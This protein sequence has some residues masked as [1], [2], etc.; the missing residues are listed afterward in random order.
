MKKLLT[1]LLCLTMACCMWGQLNTNGHEYVDLGLPSGTLW[2]KTNLGADLPIQ[3]GTLYYWGQ[4]LDNGRLVSRDSYK[5]ADLRYHGSRDYKIELDIEDDIVAQTLGGDWHTPT[6]EEF[7][8]LEENCDR[9]LVYADQYGGNGRVF[10]F[11]SRI[12]GNTI[13][14]MENKDKYTD[15]SNTSWTSEYFKGFY[16]YLYRKRNGG[17]S[18]YENENKLP[19]RP[20][21][22]KRTVVQADSTEIAHTEYDSCKTPEDML[23]HRFMLSKNKTPSKNYQ[24]FQDI[25]TYISFEGC[26]EPDGYHQKDHKVHTK[27]YVYTRKLNPGWYVVTLP[28]VY[29][30]TDGKPRGNFFFGTG[31]YQEDWISS[32]PVYPV[33][34][35]KRPLSYNKDFKYDLRQLLKKDIGMQ[36]FTFEV[37]TPGTYYIGMQFLCTGNDDWEV[38]ATGIGSLKGG[39][40]HKLEAFNYTMVEQEFNESQAPMRRLAGVPLPESVRKRVD[41]YTAL[42]L[43]SLTPPEAY[44]KIRE[45]KDF[46][47]EMDGLFNRI[48]INYLGNWYKNIDIDVT[49]FPK[50]VYTYRNDLKKG[51]GRG[52]CEDGFYQCKVL[53]VDNN[54]RETMRAFGLRLVDYQKAG[55]YKY[56]IKYLSYNEDARLIYNLEYTNPKFEEMKLANGMCAVANHKDKD[57]M[58][59]VIN[60]LWT[61]A[62]VDGMM[63]GEGVAMFYINGL[64]YMQRATYKRGV[65]EGAVS[66]S[67]YKTYSDGLPRT[68]DRTSCYVYVQGT[69]EGLYAIGE[70]NNRNKRWVDSYGQILI[71]MHRMV[72]NFENGKAIVLD[73]R[74]RER[75]IDTYGMDLGYTE[76]EMDRI[77][78][79]DLYFVQG[80]WRTDIWSY[81][82]ER[83]ALNALLTGSPVYID[84]SYWKNM[85]RALEIMDNHMGEKDFEVMR[86]DLYAKA[87]QMYYQYLED[88]EHLANEYERL[89]I[90]AS[91]SIWDKLQMNSI[92]DFLTS[93]GSSSSSSS[94]SS[95][96]EKEEEVKETTSTTT[97]EKKEEKYSASLM[98]LNDGSKLADMTVTVVFD[99]DDIVKDFESISTKPVIIEWP[100]EWGTSVKVKEIIIHKSFLLL[101]RARYIRNTIL[102]NGESR[103]VEVKDLPDE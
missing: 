21:C 4:K 80:V 81:Y 32:Q 71:P 99:K 24:Y 43:T 58:R 16:L 101:D 40:E 74:D 93:S 78:N 89:G 54:L 62:V 95:D 41:E 25:N 6:Q 42:Q 52:R 11:K 77:E 55:D 97:S 18:R 69:D 13:L 91:G 65:P 86:D 76:A 36:T 96:N 98:L 38:L 49:K 73:N 61:G 68:A 35:G 30:H 22:S 48:W 88:Q 57:P 39:K 29:S 56:S 8:E 45:M 85:Q 9:E 34:E 17:I 51:V 44:A 47:K 28:V 7:M 94:S 20:V 23:K 33:P 83:D 63:D 103:N 64:Y 82:R 37:K 72:R 84:Y 70:E 59:F 14:F 100:K 15:D 27:T 19:I 102:S 2:A 46:S 90:P 75:Y 1:L 87:K 79:A 53:N 66:L 10:V 67:I 12:N 3:L 60:A 92:S 50:G 31:I 5:Y 26:G